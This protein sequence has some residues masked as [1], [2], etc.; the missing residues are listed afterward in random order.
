MTLDG[1]AANRTNAANLSYPYAFEMTY[2]KAGAAELPTGSSALAIANGLITVSK[3]AGRVPNNQ[4]VFAIP[5]SVNIP[6][7]VGAPSTAPV[8]LGTRGGASCRPSQPQ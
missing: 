6:G 3:Q 1:V 7:S 4:A 5:S 8:A 2:T